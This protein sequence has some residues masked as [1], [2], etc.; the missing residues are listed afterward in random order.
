MC[1]A[2]II[3]GEPGNYSAYV[4]HLPGCVTVG[5]KVDE[6]IHERGESPPY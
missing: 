2:V 1:Y 5:D 6:V 3:E 4:P